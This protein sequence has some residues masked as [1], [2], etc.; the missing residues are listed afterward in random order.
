MQLEDLNLVA[1]ASGPGQVAK[2]KPERETV[3]RA[4]QREEILSLSERISRKHC[5]VSRVNFRGSVNFPF[6]IGMKSRPLR[7]IN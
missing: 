4:F 5:T 3:V 2:S 6:N 7:T 1:A